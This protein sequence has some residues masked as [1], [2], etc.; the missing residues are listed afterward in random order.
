R[1]A[2]NGK[3]GGPEGLWSSRFVRM[4]FELQIECAQHLI[5]EEEELQTEISNVTPQ[6]G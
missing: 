3:I 4:K 2:T 1:P 5:L 6:S